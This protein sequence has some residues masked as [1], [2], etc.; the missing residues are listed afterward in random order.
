[1]DLLHTQDHEIVIKY[2]LSSSICLDR[3]DRPNKLKLDSSY[4][5][6][7][8]IKLRILKKKNINY[9]PMPIA[10]KI[11]YKICNAKDLKK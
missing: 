8:I 7:K 1:M 11:A 10:A 4:Q 9:I 2:N 3:P 6:Y 5:L